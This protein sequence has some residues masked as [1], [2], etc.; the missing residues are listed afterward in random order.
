MCFGCG[1]G[2]G[3]DYYNEVN[4]IISFFFLNEQKM[5]RITKKFF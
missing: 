5:K 2:D 4:L 1:D 3:S